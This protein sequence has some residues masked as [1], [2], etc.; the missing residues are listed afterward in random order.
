MSTE[1]NRRLKEMAFQGRG[2]S[3]GLVHSKVMAK[4]RFEPGG[5]VIRAARDPCKQNQRSLAR[6]NRRG[7]EKEGRA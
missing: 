6:R 1:G 5:R 2:R 4:V 7:L 3:S